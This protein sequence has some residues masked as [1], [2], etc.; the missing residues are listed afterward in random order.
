MAVE[1]VETTRLWAHTVSAISPEQVE[2]VGSHMLSRSYSEPFFST[3]SGKVLAHESVHLLGVLVDANRR[4]SYDSIDPEAARQIFIQSG[5]VEQLARPTRGS[6]Y[7]R[8]VEHNAHMQ[9]SAEEL[10]DKARFRGMLVDDTELY[11]FF[12]SRIPPSVMSMAGLD[13]WLRKDPKNLESLLMTLKDLVRPG[14]EVSEEEY[15]DFWS[16]G[17]ANLE[18]DYRFLPGDVRDGVSVEI[19]LATLGSLDPAAFTWGVPGSREELARALIR[20]LPKPTR[21]RLVPTSEWARRALGWLEEHGADQSKPFTEELSRALFA[22]TGEPVSNWN[23]NGLPDHLR[24]L[25]QVRA[26]GQTEISRNLEAL[27]DKLDPQVAETLAEA[28]DRR[29][30]VGTTW[31]FAEI[32]DT[33]QVHDRGL[34]ATGYPGLK[35]EGDVVTETLST[36]L[37]E[38]QATHHQGLTRLAFF[39]LPDTSRWIVSS[40][41]NSD[42]LALGAGPYAS[43]ADL[44]ADARLA[45]VSDLIDAAESWQIRDP[46]SFDTLID[47]LRLDQVEATHQLVLLATDVLTQ[48]IT[49]SHELTHLP[50]GTLLRADLTGQ[51][52]NLIFNGFL[53]DMPERW[54]L[55]VPVWLQGAQIRL[56]NAKLYPGRDDIRMAKLS[57]VLEAYASLTETHPDPQEDI[58]EISYLIEELRLQTFAQT[59]RTIEKVSEKRI[60]KAIA[61]A[62]EQCLRPA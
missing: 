28:S 13:R 5:L 52:D 53:S 29:H 16:Y 8:V 9:A 44:I 45:A 20:T 32:P 62:M 1:L 4:V 23:P 40:L 39:A 55:R 54:R 3:S 14:V 10:E 34:T 26:G 60:L 35:D 48:W 61:K 57:P 47:R 18:L 59:L 33:V 17:P 56:Q 36:S 50:A 6:M 27:Q 25:F 42:K 22:L 7:A 46:D 11:E 58:K 43:V 24:M 51:L 38:A 37:D 30:A 19:P 41:S 31:V 49:L 2:Q 21:T 15:P 12:D